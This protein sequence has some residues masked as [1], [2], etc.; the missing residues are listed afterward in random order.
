MSAQREWADAAEPLAKLIEKSNQ[1]LRVSQAR[2][3]LA[4]SYAQLQRTAEAQ[5]VYEAFSKAQPSATLWNSTTYQLAEA[6]FS[7]DTAWASELFRALTKDGNAPDYVAKGLSGLAWC[8]F[9]SADAAGS[10]ATFEKLLAGHPDSPLAA[11]A[12]L[13][14]GQALEKIGQADPALG[15]YELVIDRYAG[16]PQFQEALWHAGCLSQKLSRFESAERHFRRLADQEPKFT[17][18]D[19]LLYHW[20]RVLDALDRPDDSTKLLEQLNRDF[21]TSSLHADVCYRLAERE[22]AH[23]NYLQAL[24]LVREVTASDSPSAILPHALYLQGRIACERATWDEVRPP[25]IRLTKEFP[26]SPLVLPARYWIAESLYRQQDFEHAAA[27]FGQLAADAAGRTEKWLAMAPL[28]QAQALGQR[29]QWSAALDAASPIATRYPEF[30]QQY[31]VDYVIGRAQAATADFG[32]ARES[33]TRVLRSPIGGKSETAA[34]AQWM[35]GESYLH[36]ENYKAAI[37]AYLRV[38]LLYPFPKWQ[39][40]ALLQ[41]GKCQELTA[42]WKAAAETYARLVQNYPKSEHA[43]EAKQRLSVAQQRLQGTRR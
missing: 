23:E 4:I 31:E 37:A 17:T 27:E 8:Q 26:A 20:S 34:M 39:S 7:Y 41:A 42:D 38:E 24:S 2:A 14:R 35:I 16:R 36:Q 11:E 13:A 21:P 10:A 19:A 29:G 33:Y 22:L 25:L 18:Y 40:A 43:D 30:D 32:A 5:N 28:R 12:A 15:M 6:A 1:P 3:A 9:Q